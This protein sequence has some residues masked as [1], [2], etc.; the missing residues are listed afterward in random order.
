M[1]RF[2]D[3]EFEAVRWTFQCHAPHEI[4][5]R[6]ID[7]GRPST[8]YDDE[9]FLRVIAEGNGW[10]TQS[11]TAPQPFDYG[12]PAHLKRRTELVMSL[13]SNKAAIKGNPMFLYLDRADFALMALLYRL[14]A[15]VDMRTLPV[16]E[17][18]N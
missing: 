15:R 13:A 6:L 4:R 11:M 1:Q 16:P 3:E 5:Q 9:A 10:L 7:C 8:E 14:R 18:W 12:D 17:W 2:T